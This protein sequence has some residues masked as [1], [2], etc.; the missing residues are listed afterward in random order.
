MITEKSI[1]GDAIS[2]KKNSEFV[3][4]VINEFFVP[5]G[6]NVDTEITF[7]QAAENHD[8]KTCLQ[9]L[10]DKLNKMPNADH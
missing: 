8:K 7:W 6:G 2:G 1:I 5:K 9:M 3:K 4:A 10:L